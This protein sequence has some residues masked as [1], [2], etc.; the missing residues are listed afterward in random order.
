MG[1]PLIEWSAISAL[2]SRL[3]TRTVTSTDD[4]EIAAVA[5]ASGSEVPFMRPA[6]FA[7]DDTTDLPVFQHALRWL[8]EK[9]GY[10]PDIVVHLRPTSPLRPDSLID[11]GVQKLIDNPRADSVRSVCIPL[12]NPYKMWR[13]EKGEMKPLLDASVSE[14]YNQ[15]RQALPEMYWQIGAFDA[16]RPQVILEQN[17]M[18]GR[19]ILPLVMDTG[20]AVD[21]DDEV[22]LRQAEDICRRYGMGTAQ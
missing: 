5:L 11:Q 17:S 9:E 4:P 19:V 22:S 10:R 20:M 7:A 15:P 6:E 1:R 18:S 14:Q 13:I 8:S 2:E 21:I 12:N 16:T 3:V